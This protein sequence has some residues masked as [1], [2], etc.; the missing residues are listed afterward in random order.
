MVESGG[1]VRGSAAWFWAVDAIDFQRPLTEIEDEVRALW[2]DTDANRAYVDD[3]CR[4]KDDVRRRRMG[5]LLLLGHTLQ[6]VGKDPHF[7]SLS[8]HEQ[9]KPFLVG[10]E[11]FADISLSHSEA[12]V[13]CGVILGG[14]HIGVDVEEYQ[15]ITEERAAR[16]M[17]RFFPHA[18]NET[19]SDTTADAF[20]RLWTLREA[21]CKLDG[22][23]D[24]LRVD[25][26]ALS[27]DLWRYTR[28]LDGGYLTVAVD[29]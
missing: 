26:S 17:E 25:I 9:G 13:A 29:I 4:G 21:I 12:Y 5:A 20:V 11:G 3:L 2:A 10:E 8:R 14:G 6:A 7:A 27:D 1:E 15:R 22:K 16:M 18:T 23:G 19:S 28:P 24:P